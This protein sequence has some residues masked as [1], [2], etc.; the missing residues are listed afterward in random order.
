MYNVESIISNDNGMSPFGIE[1]GHTN[2]CVIIN[3]PG[4]A[5][6]AHLQLLK[7][8]TERNTYYRWVSVHTLVLVCK[9]RK[10]VSF[11]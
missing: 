10:C 7:L 3:T 4:M 8:S 6:Q 1:T 2:C 9:H 11:Y 5:Y